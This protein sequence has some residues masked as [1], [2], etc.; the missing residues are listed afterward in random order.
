MFDPISLGCGHL[1]CYM[2]AC[3]AGS[4]SVVDGLKAACPHEKC[5]I[6]RE[7]FYLYPFS[8]SLSLSNNPKL[9]WCQ[10]GVYDNSV[11]LEELHLLL[12]RRYV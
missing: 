9:D 3:K 6:C 4:V 8:L 1:F 2:C 11:N 12:K 7:V 5:P 10:V